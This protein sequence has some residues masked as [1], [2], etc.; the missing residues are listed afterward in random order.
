MNSLRRLIFPILI[1]C[2]AFAIGIALGGGPLQADEG[3]QTKTL[4]ADNAALTNQVTTLRSSAVFEQ[5]VNEAVAP[6][7][8]AGRLTGRGVTLLALPGVSD[9]TVADTQQA[10]KLAGADVPVVASLAAT[11]LDPGKKTYVDSV[12]SSS[13]RGAPDL[14]NLKGES[15]YVRAGALVARAYVGQG[16]DANIDAEA[17][18]IDAE[19]Q[20]AKLVAS[21]GSPIRRGTFVVVLDAGGHGADSFTQAEMVIAQ[22]LIT[23]LVKGSDAL[24]VGSTPTSSESGGLISELTANPSLSGKRVSTVNVVNSA[25]GPAALVY[26]LAAAASGAPGHFGVI[27]SKAVLPPGL[28]ARAD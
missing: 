4:R 24:V 17:T 22:D 18:K 19:L 23:G 28:A 5:A 20:G 9:Q 3:D 12:V 16:S 15:T 14:D 2:L 8:L 21:D 11:L 13:L 6:K 1:G 25:A 27:D 10:L 7:L 26:A